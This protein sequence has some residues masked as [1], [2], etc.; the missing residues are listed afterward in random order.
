[1]T[2]SAPSPTEVDIDNLTVCPVHGVPAGNTVHIQAVVCPTID[3]GA[4]MRTI[5]YSDMGFLTLYNGITTTL[6]VHL[7][8]STDYIPVAGAG[9]YGC[10]AQLYGTLTKQ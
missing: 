10:V 8:T 3:E 5:I 6:D 4:A 7:Y 9:Y 2:L 1:M